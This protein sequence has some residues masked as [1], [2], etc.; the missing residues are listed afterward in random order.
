[1]KRIID[2]IFAIVFFALGVFVV[3]N[4]L[5]FILALGPMAILAAI[6]LIIWIVFVPSGRKG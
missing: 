5:G 2:A 6:L 1:M 4:L 3:V